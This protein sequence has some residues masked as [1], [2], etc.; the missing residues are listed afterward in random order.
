[1]LSLAT[2]RPTHGERHI[3]DVQARRWIPLQEAVDI[4]VDRRTPSP[5]EDW[6]VIV[7]L[8]K[9]AEV[10]CGGDDG[11]VARPRRLAQAERKVD[12]QLSIE[13]RDGLE[14]DVLHPLANSECA[15]AAVSWEPE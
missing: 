6:A 15:N 8:D 12:L 9:A 2:E 7:S 1:L 4:E 13:F 14:N 5:N 11:L 10:A 3:P